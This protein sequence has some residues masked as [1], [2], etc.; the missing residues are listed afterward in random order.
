MFSC[1][2]GALGFILSL[3][4]AVHTYCKERL[5]LHAYDCTVIEAYNKAPDS[6]FVHTV[7][8]NQSSIPCS[9][10]DMALTRLALLIFP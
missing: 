10:L 7:L 8:Y 5:S 1:L 3:A 4:L 6:V 2:I 9:V